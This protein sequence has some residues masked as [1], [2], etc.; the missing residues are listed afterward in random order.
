MELRSRI[1]DLGQ[2]IDSD[3]AKSGAALGGGV[4]LLLLAVGA[5]YDI[6]RGNASLRLTLGMTAV[7]FRWITGGLAAAALC[8]LGIAAV[9]ILRRDQQRESELGE[10]QE[11]LEQLV[12]RKD[13]P[14]R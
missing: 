2:Q 7:Q 6:L 8:M 12:D 3:N 1:S 13:L 14:R 10:L 5:L 4:F 9:R 11:E